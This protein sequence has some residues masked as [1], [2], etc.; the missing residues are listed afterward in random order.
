[1]LWNDPQ[2]GISWGVTDPI[3]SEK[4]KKWPLFKDAEYFE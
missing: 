4:D 1:V 3:I 2:L